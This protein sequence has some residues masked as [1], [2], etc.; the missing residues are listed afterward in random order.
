MY[1]VSLFGRTERVKYIVV[2]GS[3]TRW[4]K[5]SRPCFLHQHC[6]QPVYSYE[7]A[8]KSDYFVFSLKTTLF[9]VGRPIARNGTLLLLLNELFVAFHR[10]VV[11]FQKQ[12]LEFVNVAMF[13]GVYRLFLHRNI[14]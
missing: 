14:C 13:V 3:Y 5:S 9:L 1:A 10:L 6:E 2:E 11:Y 12:D 8:R 4:R 7:A